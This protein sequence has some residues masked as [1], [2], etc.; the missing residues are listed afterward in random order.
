IHCG[1]EPA[2]AGY[3][4]PVHEISGAALLR[5]ALERHNSTICIVPHLGWDEPDEF[6]AMLAEF[7]NLYLDTTMVIEGFL[8]GRDR[9]QQMVKSISGA[10][11]VGAGVFCRAKIVKRI[12][13]RWPNRILYGTD[14]PNLP[15]GWSHEL[16][17]IRALGLP[18][19]TEELLLGGNADRLFG[20]TA[21]G[22]GLAAGP[23]P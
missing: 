6:E 19:T 14:F 17:A 7:P 2:S 5:R 18:T 13:E 8:H 11:A 15:Y 3:K 23:V 10:H 20:I 12:V 4:V 22:R 21:G 16:S 1:R 9:M